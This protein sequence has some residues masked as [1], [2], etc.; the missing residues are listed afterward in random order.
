MYGAPLGGDR[1]WLEENP[2]QSGGIGRRRGG[3]IL[4]CECDRGLFSPNGPALFH[5]MLCG[6]ANGFHSALT[7]TSF[8]GAGAG[9][10]MEARRPS[11]SP[12]RSGLPGIRCRR[13]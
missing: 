5:T 8:G 12:T 7:Q 1:R 13:Q 9:G 4:F 6:G 2:R 10:G 11:R 3:K